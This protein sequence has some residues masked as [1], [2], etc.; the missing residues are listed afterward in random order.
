MINNIETKDNIK[1]T[2][3]INKLNELKIYIDNNHRKLNK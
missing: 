1:I 2:L 3:W